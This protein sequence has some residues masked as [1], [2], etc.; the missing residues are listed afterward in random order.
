[1]GFSSNSM[2]RL[3]KYS[4]LQPILR[5]CRQNG[6]MPDTAAETTILRASRSKSSPE[7]TVTWG[8]KGGPSYL[9]HSSLISSAVKAKSAPEGVRNT[10]YLCI[11]HYSCE[12]SS[13]A[14]TSEPVVPPLSSTVMNEPLLDNGNA[15]L[16]LN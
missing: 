3:L 4:S 5:I 8:S 14:C 2:N 6:R 13:V 12:L 16:S 9:P 7:Y 11:V 10:E 1:M 15:G